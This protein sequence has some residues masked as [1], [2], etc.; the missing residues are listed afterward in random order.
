M[1]HDHTWQRNSALCSVAH[2]GSSARSNAE[3]EAIFAASP[4]GAAW[5]SARSGLLACTTAVTDKR[6]KCNCCF[7]ACSLSAGRQL[8]HAFAFAEK[9][10]ASSRV[11]KLCD[12]PR[13][14]DPSHKQGLDLR[15]K[16]PY[17]LH[18]K[19]LELFTDFSSW[20]GHAVQS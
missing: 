12:L 16:R 5:S 2:P 4:L 7:S 19:I 15:C 1:I 3:P 18:F 8:P 9:M 6:R 10:P 13:L 14:N 11:N 20:K 17:M